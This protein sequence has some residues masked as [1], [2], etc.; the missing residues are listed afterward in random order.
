MVILAR[1]CSEVR[2][3]KSE[4]AILAILLFLVAV[5]VAVVFNQRAASYCA[6][7]R[8]PSWRRGAVCV[9]ARALRRGLGLGRLCG[10]KAPLELHTCEGN[11]GTAPSTQN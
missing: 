8:G 10:D 2:Y 1:S 7:S 9:H 3:D 11:A 5:A 4:K 6:F